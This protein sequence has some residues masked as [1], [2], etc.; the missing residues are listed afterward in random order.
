MKYFIISLLF[1][2][3]YEYTAYPISCLLTNT[4]SLS[5]SPE[6]S[7]TD[8]EEG[9]GCMKA[10][11]TAEMKR[12]GN[13]IDWVWS[14]INLCFKVTRVCQ[15]LGV[16]EIT[17]GGLRVLI[18]SLWFCSF[19]RLWINARLTALS[20]SEKYFYQNYSNRWRCATN[21]YACSK[22]MAL[23]GSENT[24]PSFQHVVDIYPRIKVV[25]DYTDLSTLCKRISYLNAVWND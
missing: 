2:E 10:A 1:Y 16:N 15:A 17:D 14:V 4:F 11:S 12:M 6:R 7:R 23:I 9:L 18:L 5:L 20:P 24:D 25:I 21:N 19:W 8:R 3:Q 22:T 13:D